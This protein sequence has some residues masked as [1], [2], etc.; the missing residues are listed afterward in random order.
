MK[1]RR[2]HARGRELGVTVRVTT[3]K[4]P[5]AGAYYV[6]RLPN[7]Y[8]DAEGEPPGVWLGRGAELLGLEGELDDVAFLNVMAGAHPRDSERLL[9]R[10]YDD[11]SVRGFD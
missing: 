3:L 9:G 8:L 5:E 4:G 6:E 2:V 7:Y 11:R 1:D 10:P